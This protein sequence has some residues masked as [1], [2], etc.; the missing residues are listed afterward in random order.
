MHQNEKVQSMEQLNS[1]CNLFLP[2]L[3][4]MWNLK[5]EKKSHYYVWERKQLYLQHTNPVNL[6]GQFL[7]ADLC[8]KV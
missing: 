3:V 6:Q 7:A 4:Q 5:K 1:I 8:S 2:N